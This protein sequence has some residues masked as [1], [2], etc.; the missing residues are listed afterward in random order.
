MRWR[1]RAEQDGGIDDQ[2]EGQDM[3]QNLAG[4]AFELHEDVNIH[5]Y[6]S[7]APCGDASM[8]LVMREQEDSTPWASP[9]PSTDDGVDGQTML[10][11]GHF[12]RLGVVRRKPARPDAPP[13][14]SKSCSDKLALKQC[15]GLLSALTSTIL[16][17]ENIYLS[18]LVLPENQYVPQAVERAFG[19]KGRMRCVT[20]DGTMQQRWQQAGYSFRPFKGTKTTKEFAYSK[21]AGGATTKIISN[22]SVLATSWRQE[23]LVNGVKQGRKQDDPQGASCASRRLLWEDVLKL[24]NTI[25]RHD[26]TVGG[27]RSG[28]YAEMK[29]STLLKWRNEVKRDVQEQALKEWQKNCGDDKWAIEPSSTATQ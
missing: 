1:Q 28:T 3:S 12:D 8:E 9:P 16:W 21:R 25:G 19:V 23:V 4:P 14:L 18:T 24:R 15:T 29:A 17:P 26:D 5:M 10:G 22:L 20:E 7:E 13:T 11:R 2:N 27:S 6:C